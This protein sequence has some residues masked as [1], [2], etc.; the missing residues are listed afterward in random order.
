M[1]AIAV[2]GLLACLAI[3]ACNGSSQNNAAASVATSTAL[4]APVSAAERKKIIDAATSQ[5][6]LERDKMERISFYSNKNSSAGTPK[7]EAYLS[8]P[9]DGAPIFRI[10]AQ[11]YG[12]NWIFFD[13]IKVMAD[14]QVVYDKEPPRPHHDNSGSSVWETADYAGTIVDIIA[15]K[16]I[17]AAKKVTVRFAGTE[18]REDHEM[19]PEEL[20]NLREIIASWDAMAKLSPVTT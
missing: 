20:R 19:S 6:S 17:A 12:D 1:K 9:D 11:Y 14:D 8:I 18:H 2:L 3:G 13:H 15:M 10:R 4:A 5:L 7:L 16:Q